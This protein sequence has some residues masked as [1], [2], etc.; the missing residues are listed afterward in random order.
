MEVR[1]LAALAARLRF[2]VAA[3]RRAAAAARATPHGDGGQRGS[4]VIVADGRRH[5]TGWTRRQVEKVTATSRERA[6][7]R[8]S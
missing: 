8:L 1:C 7:R 3:V 6:A 4:A 5:A 2:F